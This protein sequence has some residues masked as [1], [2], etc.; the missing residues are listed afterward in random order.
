MLTRIGLYAL[1]IYGAYKLGISVKVHQL[2]TFDGSKFCY[3]NSTITTKN[4]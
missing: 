1:G 2:T 3:K 4:V